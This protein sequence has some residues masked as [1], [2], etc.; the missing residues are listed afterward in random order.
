MKYLDNISSKLIARKE[1][2]NNKEYEK[3]LHEKNLL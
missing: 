3:Q 2:V 1:V